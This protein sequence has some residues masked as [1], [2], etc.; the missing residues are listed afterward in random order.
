MVESVVNLPISVHQQREQVIFSDTAF[1]TGAMRYRQIEEGLCLLGSNLEIKKNIIS[2]ALY[3]NEVNSNYYF[4]SFAVFE[5]SFPMDLH[6]KAK[7]TLLSTTCTFYKPK[8]EVTTFFYAGTKGK[9]FNIIFNKAWIEKNLVL[10]T[11]NETKEITEYL[12]N[13]SGF[14]NW[15]DIVPGA[16]SL[17]NDLWKLL[18]ADKE[19]NVDLIVLKDQLQEI[20][21][22]FFKHAYTDKRI[23]NHI[24]LHNPDYANVAAAEKIILNNLSAP[25]VGVENIAKAVNVSPTKL[26]VIFKSVF[27][28]S[29]LQYHK[30]KNMLL[31]MQLLQNSFMQVKNIA[32]ITGYASASKFT[33]AFKKR[34]DMLPTDLRD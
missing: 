32:S 28:F 8:T 25:F 22:S 15:I 34:F 30:E 20:I 19:G 26:K 29:M 2:K 11:P 16:A 10:S 9:F 18:E 23:K 14:I 6:S 21:S 7:A 4:L 12:N 13:E 5:Y 17:S 24:A 27:G 33:A 31:A 3:D 1:T